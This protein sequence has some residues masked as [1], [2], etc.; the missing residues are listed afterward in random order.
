MLSCRASQRRCP[1][2]L[3]RQF[4]VIYRPTGGRRARARRGVCCTRTT[5]D[6]WPH[7][8]VF[9]PLCDT[10]GTRFDVGKCTYTYC[11]QQRCDVAAT[12]APVQRSSAD[13]SVITR[14]YTVYTVCR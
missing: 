10:V 2:S 14:T 9:G 5:H 3:G 6:E 12:L 8:A 1:L 13:Q 7:V 11:Y 4:Q